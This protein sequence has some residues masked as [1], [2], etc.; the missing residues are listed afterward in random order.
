MNAFFPACANFNVMNYDINPATNR[1]PRRSTFSPPVADAWTFTALLL[2]VIDRDPTF[3][4]ETGATANAGRLRETEESDMDLM[5]L[6]A[7]GA[8][9]RACLCAIA[10]FC[11]KR[12]I[13]SC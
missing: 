10:L 13:S 3:P 6:L 12:D 11:I 2:E 1:A 8:M 4:I 9:M 7:K 5:H